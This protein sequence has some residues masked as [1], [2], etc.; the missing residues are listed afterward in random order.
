MKGDVYQN[1]H[2]IL[3]CWKTTL[4]SLLLNTIILKIS[5]INANRWVQ[6][7]H[8][9][10]SALR[11][12]LSLKVYQ[13]L[14]K[15]N[16][17][18]EKMTLLLE[19]DCSALMFAIVDVKSEVRHLHALHSL[20]WMRFQLWLNYNKI[21]RKKICLLVTKRYESI[22]LEYMRRK[23]VIQAWNDKGWVNVLNY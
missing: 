18:M 1:A 8:M 16:F 4:K 21:I 5:Q 9:T 13:L 2:A 20:M 11:T 22:T 15:I 23:K 3:T 17:P 14:L 19:A 6:Q 12:A 10:T 7:K